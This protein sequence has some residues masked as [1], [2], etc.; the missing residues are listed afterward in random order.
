MRLPISLLVATAFLVGCSTDE[1]PAISQTITIVSNPISAAVRLNGTPVGRTPTTI[2]VESNS[3]YQLEVGKGGYVSSVTE[4]KPSLK[5]DS[6]GN[7]YYGFPDRINVS[8]DLIPGSDDVKVP[9]EDATEFRRLAEKAKSTEDQ[10]IAAAGS[11]E[12]KKNTGGEIKLDVETVKTK[13]AERDAAAATK[14]EGLKKSLADEKVANAIKPDEAK[15][16]ALEA[17]IAEQEKAAAADRQ[18]TNNLLKAL[19]S[20]TDELIRLQKEGISAAKAEATKDIEAQKSIAAKEAE[21]KAKA[22]AAMQLAEVQKT[23]EEQKV[24]A[25]KEVEERTKA[26]AGK[27]LA[28]AQ[29]ATEEHKAAAVAAKEA[30]EIAKVEAA[31][32]AKAEAAKQLDAAKEEAD[33]QL[34]SVQRVMEEQKTLAAKAEEQ[35]LAAEQQRAAAE[36]EAKKRAYAEFNSRYALLESRRRNKVITEEEFKDQLSALRKELTK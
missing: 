31:E 15:I 12:S 26:E 29:K 36:L 3:D 27:Q 4:L 16:A 33:K 28:E 35:R 34:A 7:M 13:L 10:K 14:V 19:E 6:K 32:K 20:R 18:A 8:L 9:A 5:T 25:T 21:E 11:G 23:A 24:A 22:E 17:Q 1:D 30:A 2:N